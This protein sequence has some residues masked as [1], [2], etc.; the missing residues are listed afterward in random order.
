MAASP[1]SLEINLT[2]DLFVSENLCPAHVLGSGFLEADTRRIAEVGWQ[3][4][5]AGN[6][7]LGSILPA[8]LS[9]DQLLTT[10]DLAQFLG[11]P[12]HDAAL[13]DIDLS[14]IDMAVQ[15]IVP[16][17]GSG[18]LVSLV[19]FVLVFSVRRRAA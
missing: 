19:A 18:L 6:Y 15:Y 4:I 10:I 8:G 13:F 12:G 7:L 3:G 5:P 2:D 16:E 9:E 17:P 14:G 1:F 11:E